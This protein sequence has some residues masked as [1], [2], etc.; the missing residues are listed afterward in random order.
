LGDADLKSAGRAGVQSRILKPSM[1]YIGAIDFSRQHSVTYKEYR[2]ARELI[3][4]QIEH[5]YAVHLT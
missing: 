5:A 2:G 1:G 4:A 3:Q